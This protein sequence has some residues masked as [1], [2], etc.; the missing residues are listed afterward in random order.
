[1]PFPVCTSCG[2]STRS[3]SRPDLCPPCN[4]A[5]LAFVTTFGRC[6]WFAGCTSPAT[7][8]TP[9]PVIGQV[10]TCFKCHTFATPTKA[11]THVTAY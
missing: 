2:K 11:G 9:H 5:R 7:G 8:T 6:E 10:P 4:D 1:M 3:H